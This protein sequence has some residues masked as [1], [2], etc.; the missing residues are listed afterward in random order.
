VVTG[1]GEQSEDEASDH[2]PEA[3]AVDAWGDNRRVGTAGASDA[4]S[5]R[6]RE[7]AY[8]YEL[9]EVARRLLRG[10]L[11]DQP[12]EEGK[13]SALDRCMR[14]LQS[15]AAEV[16]LGG[17]KRVWF[18]GVQTC[19]SVWHCPVCSH[20]ILMRRRR[21]LAT[22]LERHMAAGG[23]VLMLTLVVPHA[24]DEP[25]KSVL[26]RLK[27]ARDVFQ[28]DGTTGRV[29]G[30]LGYLG[31]IRLLEVL[32]QTNGWHPHLHLLWLMERPLSDDERHDLATTLTTV[33]E[34]VVTAQG[35][36][37]CARNDTL[38][39]VSEPYLPDTEAEHE[40]R[41]RYMTKLAEGWSDPDRRKAG[42]T[43]LGP[44]QLL[45]LARRGSAWAG[46]RFVEYA[47]ATRGEHMVRWSPGLK[48]RLLGQQ[49]EE[50]D[51]QIAVEEADSVVRIVIGRQQWRILVAADQRQALLVAAAEGEAAVRRF[52]E[53]WGCGGGATTPGKEWPRCNGRGDGDVAHVR[54]TGQRGRGQYPRRGRRRARLRLRLRRQSAAV[55]RRQGGS[56]QGTGGPASDGAGG[57]RG[58]GVPGRRGRVPDR[59]RDPPVRGPG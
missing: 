51:R 6:L 53:G 25:L 52:L 3:A 39:V 41:A 54:R 11:N 17:G 34:R 35:G 18:E 32:R 56:G 49:N 48:K 43:G 20:R 46:E 44:A 28:K 1:D 10:R 59:A 7:Q 13:P 16:C 37:A 45:D 57:D 31:A 2:A 50:S 23:D 27:G 55:W 24:E 36:P 29:R 58:T 38:L 15:A 30:R 5:R 21:E 47:R 4:R 22:G 9:Q 14:S 33:W 40:A 26:A 19:G 42:W 8:R 12:V